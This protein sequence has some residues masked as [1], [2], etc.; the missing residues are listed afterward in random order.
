MGPVIR[1]GSIDPVTRLMK[2]EVY[3]DHYYGLLLTDY[4]IGKSL[5]WLGVA[6]QP[7]VIAIPSPVKQKTV[8]TASATS[9]GWKRGRGLDLDGEEG[10][11]D[12]QPPPSPVV[13]LDVSE[14]RFIISKYNSQVVAA[15]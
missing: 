2:A 13:M 14:L 7:R 4:A 8:L 9:L 1:A 3:L 15:T 12:N 6:V 10:E 11:Y 5:I